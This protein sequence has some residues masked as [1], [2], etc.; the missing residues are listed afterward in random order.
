MSKKPGKGKGKGKGGI[1]GIL[2]F[3]GPWPGVGGKDSVARAQGES[4]AG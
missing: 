2:M 4:V 1:D 3:R